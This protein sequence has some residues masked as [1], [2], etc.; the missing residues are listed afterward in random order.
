MVLLLM[1]QNNPERPQSGV[2]QAGGCTGQAHGFDPLDE[3]VCDTQLAEPA[4]AGQPLP[5]A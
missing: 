5:R 3:L 2:I 4:G 1:F